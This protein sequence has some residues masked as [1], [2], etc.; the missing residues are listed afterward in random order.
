VV[1]YLDTDLVIVLWL[2]KQETTLPLNA[3]NRAVNILKV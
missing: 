1:Q 3:I 2:L